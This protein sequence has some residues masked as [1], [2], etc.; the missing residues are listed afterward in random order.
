MNNFEKNELALFAVEREIN[1]LGMTTIHKPD[2]FRVN[3]FVEFGDGSR[4][5][6]H[7]KYSSEFNNFRTPSV[8]HIDS[9][10]LVGLYLE[11]ENSVKLCEAQ[12]VL[13]KWEPV[14]RDGNLYFDQLN[15]IFTTNKKEEVEA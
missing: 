12:E 11:S 8:D 3:L 9:N 10:D 1:K 2:A 7:Y 5:K 4:R 13:D 6:V 15:G 14:G